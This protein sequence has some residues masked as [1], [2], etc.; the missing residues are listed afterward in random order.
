MRPQKELPE[1]KPQPLNTV[2]LYLCPALM[3]WVVCFVS[4]AVFYAAGARGAGLR[5][6]GWLGMLYQAA[7]MASSLVS[8]HVITRRN[9]RAVLWVSTLGCGVSSAAAL[10]SSAFAYLAAGLIVFGAAVAWFFNSFQAVMRGEGALG[11]LK[12]SVS[13]YTLSWCMGSALG[14]LTSG[15]FFQGGVTALVAAVLIAT[16]A[17]AILLARNARPSTD[18]PLPEETVEHGTRQKYPVSNAYIAVGWLMIF[19]VT[20]VQRP[21]FTFLPPLFAAEGIGSLQASLPL[22]L[23]LAV[24]AVFGLFLYRYRDTLYRRTPFVIF[25]S[26]GAAALCAMWRWPTYWVCF[27]M[28]CLLGI[29][30]GYAYYCAVY[31]ASNSGRRSFNIGVNEALVGFGS[32][33]GILLGDLWMRRSGSSAG[34]YLVCAAGLALSLIVQ[35]GL[36]RRPC[37]PQASRPPS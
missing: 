3:D 18:G 10:G 15:W 36:A 8:G 32:V 29:Y 22:F 34:L 11:S 1:I 35:L 6:C 13:L 12:S 14:T 19:T 30:A 37:P 17:M 7:Y 2:G 21:I 25:Q 26:A 31:Y 27:S 24:S 20:F 4:F 16:A 28:L 23:H 33:A 9:A 5:E